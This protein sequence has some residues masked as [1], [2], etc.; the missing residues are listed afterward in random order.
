M[1]IDFGGYHGW[2]DGDHFQYFSWNCT[3]SENYL[4]SKKNKSKRLA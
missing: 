4:A 3:S 1:A 2:A